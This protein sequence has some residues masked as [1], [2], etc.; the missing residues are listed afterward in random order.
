MTDEL[1]ETLWEAAES[2][3]D[4][5]PYGPLLAGRIQREVTVALRK[6]GKQGTVKVLQGGRRV[7]VHLREGPRV[8]V[9]VI[10]MGQV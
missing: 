2:A 9:V 10:G 8:R 3:L 5:S 7:E 4:G 1:K 6:A